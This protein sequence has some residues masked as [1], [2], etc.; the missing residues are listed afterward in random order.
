M[1]ENSPTRRSYAHSN[2][3]DIRKW[4]GLESSQP[5][6]NNI[7]I[8]KSIPEETLGDKTTLVAEIIDDNLSA[9]AE[10]DVKWS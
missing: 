6:L 7:F 1:V 9:N 4:S 5:L 8:F 2:L 10:F 3:V